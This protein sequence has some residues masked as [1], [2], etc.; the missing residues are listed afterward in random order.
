M[1]RKTLSREERAPDYKIRL[2]E[3]ADSKN[4]L[5]ETLGSLSDLE[6]LPVEEARRALKSM[7][8]SSL[9]RTLVAV[10]ADGQVIGSTTLLVEQ[11]LIHKAGRVGHIEDVAVRKG[12]EDKGVGSSLVEAAVGMASESGCYKVILDCKE[13]LVGFYEKLG[14]KRHEVAMRLDLRRKR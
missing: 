8:H 5:L 12:F 2:V 10:L 13:E 4:G 14:F 9:Y 3:E 11:K 7:A 6:G 1:A